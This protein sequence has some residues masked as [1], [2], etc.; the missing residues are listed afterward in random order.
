MESRIGSHNQTGLASRAITVVGWSAISQ[1]VLQAVQFLTFVVLARLLQ[2]DDFG[3]L[4]MTITATGLVATFSQLGISHAIVQRQK[5]KQSQV[6]A[7]FWGNLFVG[8]VIALALIAISPLISEFFND[9]RL[10][11]I[12]RVSAL[13]FVLGSLPATHLALLQR[14]LRFKEVGIV[15][16]VG[17][18]G[19]S[20][21]SIGMAVTGYGLWSLVVGRLIVGPV[22]LIAAHFC[23]PWRIR[24]SF[25]LK[26]LTS[27]LS[28]GIHISTSN[29]INY[30]TANLDY[31]LIGRFLGTEVLG[32]YTLGYNLMQRPLMQLSRIIPQALFPIFCSVQDQEKRLVRGYLRATH[33]VA[34]VMFPLMAGCAVVAPE[35]ILVFFGEKWRAAIPLVRV[36]CLAGVAKSVGMNIA[37]VF[38]AKG[39]PDVGWKWNLFILM[40]YMP[41]FPFALRWGALG[42]ALAISV[43]SVPLLLLW[44][45]WLTKLVKVSW[46]DYLESLK[47]PLFAS[48]MMGA[49]AWGVR[50]FSIKAGL[51]S[52]LV[53]VLSGSSGAFVYVGLVLFRDRAAISEIMGILRR[54]YA[55]AERLI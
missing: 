43:A 39:R 13:G 3:L 31:L 26:A 30:V 45:A 8:S 46:F 36:L 37:L 16:V 27:L 49:A 10:L 18:L 7:S 32:V 48:L 42:I 19:S 21:I 20:A 14:N 51:S 29:L 28:F 53:L 38:N 47:L 11:N 25:S 54:R 50:E 35:L 22:S 34:L 1:I 23:E 4:A 40:I 9:A 15:T 24:L 55:W 2:P 17:A 12:L 33:Y 52:I 41:L 6:L 5:L 44:Q